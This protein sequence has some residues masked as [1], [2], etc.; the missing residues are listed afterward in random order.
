MLS[1]ALL[2]HSGAWCTCSPQR[3][4]AV[5]VGG[6]MRDLASQIRHILTG[7]VNPL[8]RDAV[9]RQIILAIYE[10]KRSGGW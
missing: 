1:G 5:P 6:T 8:E 4:D 9:V 2:S 7:H 3:V 10:D